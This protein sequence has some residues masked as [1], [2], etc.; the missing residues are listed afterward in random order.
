[1]P[2]SRASRRQTIAVVNTDDKGLDEKDM[3]G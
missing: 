3:K 2:T 1:M